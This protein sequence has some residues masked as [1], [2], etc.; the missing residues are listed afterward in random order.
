MSEYQHAIQILRANGYKVTRPRKQVLR[1]LDKTQEAVSPYDIQKILEMNGEHLNHVTIY[2][3]LELLCNLNLAHKVLLLNGFVKCSLGEKEG[4]HRFMVCRECGMLK[5]FA[6]E[7]L[8]I[9]EKEITRELG[10]V[11]EQHLAESVGLCCNCR[12]DHND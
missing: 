3:I 6:D 1:V 8:C 12:K 7:S 5:E 9:E 2:R 10:F 11:T 4:C